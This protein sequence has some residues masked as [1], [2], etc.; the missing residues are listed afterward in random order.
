[1]YFGQTGSCVFQMV[2]SHVHL[3]LVDWRKEEFK[4]GEYVMIHEGPC[5]LWD[6]LEE[7]WVEVSWIYPGSE[8]S[9]Q[10]ENLWPMSTETLPRNMMVH[11]S[12]QQM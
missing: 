5:C 4:A 12:L 2:G 6:S 8:E 1:M 3:F 11:L 10:N 9:S 7:C